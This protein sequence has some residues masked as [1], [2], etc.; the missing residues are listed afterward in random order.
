MSFE[1]SLLL[2]EDAFTQHVTEEG[3]P[4]PHWDDALVGDVYISFVNRLLQSGMLTLSLGCRSQAGIFFVR[5]KKRPFADDRRR[6]TGQPAHE[7]STEDF[8]AFG[9]RV[10]GAAAWAGREAE[11]V[12]V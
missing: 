9:R 2:S 10:L 8:N 11:G 7:A 3:L 6:K 12:N 5:K 1:E 4:T